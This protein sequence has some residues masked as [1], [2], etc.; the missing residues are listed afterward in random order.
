MS[1][2]TVAQGETWNLTETLEFKKQQME[3]ELAEK[4]DAFSGVLVL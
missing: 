4:V 1:V 3:K 2:D